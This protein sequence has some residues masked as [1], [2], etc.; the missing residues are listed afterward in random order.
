M[1]TKR[2]STN[3]KKNTK[4]KAPARKPSAKKAAANSAPTDE[5][6]QEAYEQALAKYGARAE[7]TAIDI[8]YQYDQGKRT[9]T[10][11]VRI[12]VSEKKDESVL[13]A[14]AIFPRQ[15]GNVPVDVIEA[16]YRVQRQRP[17]AKLES[18]FERQSR[19]DPMQP[20]I[21]VAHT[22][23]TA[24]T[25]GNLVYDR[26]DGA[27]CILSNWHVLAGNNGLPGDPILQPGKADGGR[28]PEDRVGELNRSVLGADGDAAIAR[29][30]GTRGIS[31]VQYETGVKVTSARMP[32]I[33]EI[34]SKSGRTTA[35]TSGRVDG[36]GRYFL[37]Y[38]APQGTVGVDG[39]KIV[40]VKDGNPDN[41][42]L[43]MGGDSG[44]CWHIDG[45]G[46]GV[47][48]HFAG[49]TNANAAEEHAIACFLPRV[50]DALH[51]DLLPSV[52]AAPQGVGV[53][54]PR[55]A[56]MERQLE[57]VTEMLEQLL[58]RSSGLEGAAIETES[59]TL[60]EV[61]QAIADDVGR[62]ISRVRRLD[63]LSIFYR[64]DFALRDFYGAV[65]NGSQFNCFPPI[66][67]PERPRTSTVQALSDLVHIRR[68]T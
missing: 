41:E 49:E 4:T 52:Q 46:I 62:D 43:S 47:G 63:P 61:R 9:E 58:Q 38:G 64:S 66:T 3:Q 35:V 65:I 27:P 39:F 68:R 54:Q 16:T 67:V 55:L 25:F 19:R 56:A 11:S 17:G 36:M 7:V 53:A 22:D 13:E 5:E 57:F 40:P 29:L 60:R 32:R 12:H 33:G 1:S 20:G 51:V 18:L 8:G 26:A 34:V 15:I 23:V 28:L 50:L 44:A 45:Q 48:L 21:S 30:D 37:P 6:L 14:A 10:M 42:E 31:D 24:G 59:E 2:K